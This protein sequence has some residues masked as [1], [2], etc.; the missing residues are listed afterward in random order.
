MAIGGLETAIKCS[1]C[2]NTALVMRTYVIYRGNVGQLQGLSLTL[3][4]KNDVIFNC[5]WINA[6]KTDLIF[7]PKGSTSECNANASAVPLLTVAPDHCLWTVS[8]HT[9]HSFFQWR[10]SECFPQITYLYVLLS[11][12]HFESS[13]ALHQC[14]D[15]VWGRGVVDLIFP[16][17]CCHIIE[18]IGIELHIWADRSKCVSFFW[19]PPISYSQVCV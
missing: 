6:E 17:G 14:G 7:M 15:R 2:S 3:F 12:W 9:K 1:S 5:S 10:C 18:R 8:Y 16:L 13:L 11:T 19:R 4:E